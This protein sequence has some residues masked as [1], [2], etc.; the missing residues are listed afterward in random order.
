MSKVFNEPWLMKFADFQVLQQTLLEHI[1]SKQASMPVPKMDERMPSVYLNPWE[2]RFKAE[3]FKT[4]RGDIAVIPIYGI[5]GKHL[6]GLEIECG[7]CSLDWVMNGLQKAAEDDSIKV[8]VP[9]FST[10]GGTVT[11]VPE[12]GE[13]IRKI[14]EIKPVIAY[15]ENMMFSAGYWMGSQC[16]KIIATPS[17]SIGSIGVYQAWYD[18]TEAYESAGHKLM[19][20][21]AGKHKAIG[22]RPPTDE[23][24]E[25][26]QKEVESLHEDF[27]ETILSVRPD[28]PKDA[29]EGLCYFGH[30]A[31]RLNL[32][33]G[34][35]NCF[36]DL[37]DELTAE[38]N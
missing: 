37:L 27:K 29:M 21:E 32:V 10:P 20:F 8:V 22:L 38:L 1:Q 2:D 36:D 16:D 12:V 17:A 33:D 31:K 7:G 26:L 30:E 19:L 13:M 24:M 28:V 14:S 35:V 11:G 3:P 34:L 23:E 4:V 18:S 6:S 5:I 25:M 9:D 15:T